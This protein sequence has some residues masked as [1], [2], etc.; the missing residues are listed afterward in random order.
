MKITKETDLLCINQKIIHEK[1]D[2]KENEE[3]SK[4]KNSEKDS[5]FTHVQEKTE[6]VLFLSEQ[7]IIQ[8]KK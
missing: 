2:F 6:E 3:K 5:I 1:F 8:K 7:N 4:K